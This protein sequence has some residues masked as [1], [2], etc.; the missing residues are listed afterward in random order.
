MS[1]A[2]KWGILV[3]GIIICIGLVVGAGFTG[4]ISG[5]VVADGVSIILTYCGTALK[6]GRGLINN[7]FFPSAYPIVTF[8]IWWIVLKPIVTFG[9]KITVSIYHYIFK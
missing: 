4:Y 2:I 6:Y 1:D 5:D 9:I 3:A 7:F 8:S